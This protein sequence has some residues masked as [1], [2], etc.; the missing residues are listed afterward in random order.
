[1]KGQGNSFRFDTQNMTSQKRIDQIQ[2]ELTSLKQQHD[3][4]Q[5][6]QLQVEK[7]RIEQKQAQEGKDKDNDQIMSEAVT[8]TG[9]KTSGRIIAAAASTSYSV[10]QKTI[11]SGAANQ[12]AT[13]NTHEAKKAK[14]AAEAVQAARTTNQLYSEQKD[15]SLA[16]TYLGI[17][18]VGVIDRIVQPKHHF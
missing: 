4:T 2:N 13:S 1:M 6:L 12:G 8:D 14:I 9:L 17:N 11:N 15:G 16:G 18:T 3:N 7:A 5:G 10:P